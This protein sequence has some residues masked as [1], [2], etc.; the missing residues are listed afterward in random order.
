MLDEPLDEVH[1]YVEA[2]AGIL[3]FHVE[4]TRHPHRV[5]ETLAGTGMVR[6]VALNAGRLSRQLS[7]WSMNWS[8]DEV[9]TL[10]GGREIV[11]AVDGG[12]TKAS[13]EHFASLGVDILVTGSAVYDGT[14]PVQQRT[15]GA[16]ACRPRADGDIG[17]TA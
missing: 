13:V 9:R 11:V 17:M 12:M 5:L 8:S 10:I 4:S 15:R 16:R 1:A 6:G 14:E 7:R 2:G 3:T